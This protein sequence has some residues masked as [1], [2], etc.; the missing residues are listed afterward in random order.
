MTRKDHE[1][2]ATILGDNLERRSRGEFTSL[3]DDFARW[4]AEDNPNFDR[5]RFITAIFGA[6]PLA[7]DVYEEVELRC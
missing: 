3:V 4:L 1:T 2:I 5:G 7:A 6:R